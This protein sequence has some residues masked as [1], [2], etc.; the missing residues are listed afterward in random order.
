MRFG[1]FSIFDYWPL[2]KS[3]PQY[4]A[5]IIHLAEKAEDLR[6]DS[7]WISEHHFTNYGGILPR[8]QILL[9][10]LAQ[11]T[12]TI[13]LGTAVS[14]IPFDSP[15]RL[16]E[17]FGLIDVLSGGRLEFGV[18]RGLFGFEY[19]GLGI[20]QDEGR[21]RLEEGVNVIREAWQSEQ[22]TYQGRFTNVES[23]RVLPQPLQKPYPPLYVAAV[24]PESY[25]WAAREGHSILQ[26]LYFAPI[27][28][29][30][31]EVGRYRMLLEHNRHN[32]AKKRLV[33]VSPVHVATSTASARR[34]AAE[35]LM[36][37]VGMVSALLPTETKS[38][39]YRAYT[40]LRPAMQKLT[41]D[42]LY[43]E[44]PTVIG[45]PEQVI[46]RIESMNHTLGI[47]EFVSFVNFGGMPHE[48]IL[49]SME[50]FATRVIPHF[51]Q[52]NG[53]DAEVRRSVLNVTK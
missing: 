8:P 47:D 53:N 18:G 41:Y 28:R 36:N 24:S 51:R 44:R 49:K 19:D 1:I 12:H 2:V 13:R 46:Q 50:L 4:F 45:D 38:E 26:V 30:A 43:S 20:Q 7:F 52:S 15:V 40:K 22:F 14:L 31:Q 3:V 33:A 23:L 39:Q 25:E 35:P 6:F 42:V 34:E 11:R 48:L 32:P 21:A 17:D 37:Y 5:D 16:A 9:A 29:T 10:A 27:E